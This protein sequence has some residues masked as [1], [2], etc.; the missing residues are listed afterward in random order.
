MF[1]R[2][3]IKRF[4]PKRLSWRRVSGEYFEFLLGASHM[5]SGRGHLLHILH[6]LFPLISCLSIRLRIGVSD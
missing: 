4:K 3:F 2:C 5:V 1:L 6:H